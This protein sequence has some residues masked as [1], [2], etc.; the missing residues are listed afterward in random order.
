MGLGT[1]ISLT[2]LNLDD[3]DPETAASTIFGRIVGVDY[4]SPDVTVYTL[5]DPT[6]SDDSVLK[7]TLDAGSGE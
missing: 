6:W 1:L 3:P 4:P 7:L 2:V 5:V